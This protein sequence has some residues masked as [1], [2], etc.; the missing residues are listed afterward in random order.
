MTNNSDDDK[1]INF[2]ERQEKKRQSDEA[3]KE[4]RVSLLSALSTYYKRKGKKNSNYEMLV[5]DLSSMLVL[6]AGDGGLTSLSML[7]GIAFWID[8]LSA[9]R[10]TDEFTELFIEDV[11]HELFEGFNGY[12][13]YQRSRHENR[14]PQAAVT[15]QDQG[16]RAYASRSA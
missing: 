1:L 16:R 8:M 6:A 4:F 7:Q 5:G 2:L 14:R 3:A 15:R 11:P 12:E 9:D 10:W 13:T